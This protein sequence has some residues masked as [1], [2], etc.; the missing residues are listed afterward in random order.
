M[1]TQRPLFAV[2]IT[3]LLSACDITVSQA[4]PCLEP[5]TDIVAENC[6]PGDPATEWDI[7]GYGDPSIQGF[8]TDISVGQGETIEFK[9]DTD[10]NDY[11]IDMYRMGYYGG[12]GARRVDTIEPS[13]SLP[14]VQPDCLTGDIPVL[15]EA[16]DVVTAEAPLFD[17]GNWAVSALWDVPTAATS[18]IYFARLVRED[19]LEGEWWPND[20]FAPRDLPVGAEFQVLRVVLAQGRVGM[21]EVWHQGLQFGAAGVGLP[22][23]GIQPGLGFLQFAPF[24]HQRLAFLGGQGSFHPVADLVAPLANRFQF[25]AGLPGQLVRFQQGL[26]VHCDIAVADVFLHLFQPIADGAH[27]QHLSLLRGLCLS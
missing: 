16:G 24:F 27:F 23:F 2:T 14:Q 21:G 5:T 19:P 10:S 1:S 13:V 7:N 4:D 26:N 17:C 15:D 25:R 18:G 22:V 6:L 20:A 8:G 9:I 11:R 3:F 12:M